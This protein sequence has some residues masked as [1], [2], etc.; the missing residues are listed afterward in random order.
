MLFLTSACKEVQ[1]VSEKES[2]KRKRK[3]ALETTQRRVAA[4]NQNFII[5]KERHA[6]TV[7][8]KDKWLFRDDLSLVLI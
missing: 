1:Q 6:A 2:P 7:S 5:A 4:Q 3:L 8:L